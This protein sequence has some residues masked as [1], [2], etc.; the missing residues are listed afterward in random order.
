MIPAVEL[1]VRKRLVREFINVDYADV[2]F[3]RKTR[4]KTS[5]GGYKEVELPLSKAQR[6]RLIPNKRRF[7][8]TFV[9]TEAGEI[10][11]WPYILITDTNTDIKE[12]DTFNYRGK[13]YKVMSIEPD[14]EERTLAA[15]DYYGE[16]RPL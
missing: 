8:S 7:A 1:M 10:E 2:V 5:A 15:L 6:I 16:H 14:R 9:N 13:D 12:N 11:K 4:L 3:I